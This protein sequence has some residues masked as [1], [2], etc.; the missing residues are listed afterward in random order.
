MFL[1]IN[2]TTLFSLCELRAVAFPRLLI[3]L[4]VIDRYRFFSLPIVTFPMSDK[5]NFVF[6]IKRR[7]D[8]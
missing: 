3:F 8:G 6:N 2:T 5:L 4:V 7:K 1:K